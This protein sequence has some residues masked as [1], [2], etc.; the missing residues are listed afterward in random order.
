MFCVTEED[1]LIHSVLFCATAALPLIHSARVGL[2]LPYCYVSGS[3]R[4]LPYF[5]PLHPPSSPLRRTLL[6]S[7]VVDY[8]FDHFDLYILTGAVSAGL[9]EF[10]LMEIADSTFPIQ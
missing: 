10:N 2:D 1:F 9:K 4:N 8:S 5:F 6:L 7:R 3:V